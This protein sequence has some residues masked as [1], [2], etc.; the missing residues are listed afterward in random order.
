LRCSRSCHCRCSYKRALAAVHYFANDGEERRLADLLHVGLWM[1]PRWA[2]EVDD[3]DEGS[4]GATSTAIQ[5]GLNS[6]SA[7]A[8]DA[9]A[10]PSA[11]DTNDGAGEADAGSDLALALEAQLRMEP[12][13]GG[14]VGDGKTIAAP[15]SPSP[16]PSA[17]GVGAMAGGA[18]C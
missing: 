1:R 14:A 5:Y 4:K 2:D 9:P 11:A 15:A 18:R 17:S 7:D 12:A 8:A 10:L 16:P 3:G 6:L 13:N